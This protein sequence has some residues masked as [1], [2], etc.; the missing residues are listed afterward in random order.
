MFQRLDLARLAL[1]ATLLLTCLLGWGFKAHCLE[2]G[3]WPSW[4]QYSTGCY[5]DAIPFWTARDVDAGAVPYFESRMEYPVLTGLLI[6]IEGGLARLTGASGPGST[7]FLFWVTFGNALL[8]FAIL[9]MLYRA[10]MND[11]RLKRW[12]LAPPLILYLGH[13]WD[14]LAVALAVAAMLTARQGRP[15]TAAAL[16]GLGTAAKLFPALLLPLL[17]LQALFGD[18]ERPLFER[19]RNAALLSAAAIGAWLLV[20]LPV[21]LAAFENWSEF[22]RFS[23][24]RPGTRASIWEILNHLH[25]WRATIAERNFWSALA[26]FAG[27]AAIVALGWRRHRTRLWILFPAVLGWFLLTNKVHSPQ[28]DLWI[29]PLLLIA[30]PRLWPVALFAAGDLAA[31]FAE[32]WWLARMN[33]A[34]PHATIIPVALAAGVRGAALL[35]LIADLVRLPSP[36]WIEEAARV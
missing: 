6:W 15:A 27:Y 35:W 11:A 23:G 14:M 36:R 22:Y 13:N 24:S 17:G 4:V 2:N 18:S 21:A 20:N 19:I 25:V 26:F 1:P 3:G 8:A 12:A 10:G 34:W 31:Y 5:S 7:H 30:A 16:A 28:F 33:G 9:A 32:F 29:Y